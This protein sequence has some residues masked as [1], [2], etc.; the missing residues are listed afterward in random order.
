MKKHFKKLAGIYLLSLA[1]SIFGFLVD[2]DEN[3]NTILMNAFEIT[4]MSFVT[5]AI[6]SGI[7]YGVYSLYCLLGNKPIQ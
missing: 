7:I 3:T 2:S 4:M 5:F 1:I 6:L